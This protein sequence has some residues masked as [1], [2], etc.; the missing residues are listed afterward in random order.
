[1][2]NSDGVPHVLYAGRSGDAEQGIGT[3]RMPAHGLLADLANAGEAAVRGDTVFFAPF[4]RD[5]VLALRANGETLWV[6]S[7]GLPQDTPE[8]RFELLQGQAVIDYHPV[9]LGLTVGPDGRLYVLST[10]G[11]TTDRARLDVFDP[12]TGHLLR[13]GALSTALPTLAVEPDGRVHLLDADRL[14]HR[15]PPRERTPFPPFDLPRLDGGRLASA[16]LR[17][18]VVLVNFWASWC[19]PCRIEMPAL[20]SLRQRMP[21]DAF[22]LITLS[23]DR[24]AAAASRFLTEHHLAFAAVWGGGQQRERYHYPGLPYTVLL[25]RE[26]RVVQRWIGFAGPVQIDEIE[27]L[28][29]RELRRGSVEDSLAHGGVHDPRHGSAGS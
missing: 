17:G 24:S 15:I 6:A 14:V 2:S 26:G 18:K 11:P 4:I 25:D 9:N 21:D 1:M 27:R 8:P 7:R 10:A 22:A 3:P 28:A 5:E 23:E 16:D 20:D 19:T 29:R 12:A 13:T